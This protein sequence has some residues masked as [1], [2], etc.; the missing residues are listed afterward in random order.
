MY[1]MQ[2]YSIIADFFAYMQ[3][4]R[5]TIATGV[6]GFKCEAISLQQFEWMRTIWNILFKKHKNITCFKTFKNLSF[7]T[8]EIHI[9]LKMG[10]TSRMNRLTTRMDSSRMRTVR[11][12]GRMSGGRVPG[13]GGCT[14]SWGVY[15]V[16]GGLP[17]PGGV[18][19]SAPGGGHLVRYSPLWT[20]TRL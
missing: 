3:L 20:D 6:N 2:T 16:P 9:E 18:C 8:N 19:L 1:A 4:P 14:W 17:G 13:P 11:S 10:T 15:L 5:C 7:S 12:S